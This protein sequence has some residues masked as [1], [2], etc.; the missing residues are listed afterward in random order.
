MQNDLA[1]LFS[2]IKFL[3]IKPYNEWNKFRYVY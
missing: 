1:E 2:Q 3:R